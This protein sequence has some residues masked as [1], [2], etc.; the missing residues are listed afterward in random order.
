MES[1]ETQAVVN[2]A[3][4]QVHCVILDQMTLDEEKKLTQDQTS[5]KTMKKLPVTQDTQKTQEIYRSQTYAGT[6]S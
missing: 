5:Y 1:S 3:C 2:A 6:C 4:E